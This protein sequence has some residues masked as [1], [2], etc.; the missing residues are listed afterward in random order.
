VPTLAKSDLEAAPPLTPIL[1]EING[2]HLTLPLSNSLV[3]GRT[4]MVPG[5]V[6]PDVGLNDFCAAQHGVSRQHIRIIRKRNVVYVS[7]LNSS[8]GTCL[9]GRP[10][11]RNCY[12][13]LNSGDELQLGSL[14]LTLNF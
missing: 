13:V 1:C 3:I 9:N 2:K 4:T 7:D 12:R 10:L 6:G 5:D 14:K 8:N 11:P